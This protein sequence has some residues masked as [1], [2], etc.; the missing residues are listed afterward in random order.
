RNGHLQSPH[1]DDSGRP[2]MVSRSLELYRCAPHSRLT[3]GQSRGGGVRTSNSVR[4][5]KHAFGRVAVTH[6]QGL[7]KG[8]RALGTLR[9]LNTRLWPVPPRQGVPMLTDRVD[10]QSSRQA[11]TLPSR[12][13]FGRRDR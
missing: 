7:P 5:S 12:P 6:V 4:R 10:Q 11:T 3:C 8:G 13:L 2:V 1:L 9:V